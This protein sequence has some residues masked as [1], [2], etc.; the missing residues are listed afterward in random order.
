[1]S[2]ADQAASLFDE[3]FSCSQSVL[4]TFCERYGL[5]RATAFRL[6]DAFGGGLGGLGK[7]CGAV[8][9]ALMVIGLAHGRT[10]ADD[11]AAKLA[12]NE[13]VR[14]L[15]AQFTRRH[16]TTACRDLLG[17]EI[18]TPEKARAAR[19]EGRFDRVCVPLVRAAA[20][21]LEAALA[22]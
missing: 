17:C 13:R 7:T 3:G 19:D 14:E 6:A 8:T 1:M 20:E 5:P 9:G 4:G 10:V 18:D 16:G 11:P 2:D 22:R 12:T 21:L 15:M